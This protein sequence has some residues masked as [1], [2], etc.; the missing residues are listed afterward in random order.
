MDSMLIYIIVNLEVGL[1]FNNFA[2]KSKISLNENLHYRGI[3]YLNKKYV[4][5]VNDRKTLYTNM[6][7]IKWNNN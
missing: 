4:I 6:G 2:V 1:Q 7:D 3:F 5:I